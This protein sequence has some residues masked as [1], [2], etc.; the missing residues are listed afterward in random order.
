ME[1]ILA[2]AATR[3]DQLNQKSI[4]AV[5]DREGFLLGLWDM[6]HRLP[7]QLP[8]IVFPQ[9]GDPTLAKPVADILKIYSL[10]AGAVTRASTAAFLSSDGEAFTSRTAGF[11]I[12]Q[13][14]PPGIRNTSTGPLVGVGLSSL[15]FSD[16][17]RVNIIPPNNTDYREGLRLFAEREDKEWSLV[18]CISFLTM[19][20]MGITSALSKDHHFKQAGFT[21]LIGD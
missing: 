17:N 8:V 13:H 1:L 12:Q 10:A 2:Q 7:R 20:R 3:A 14:F 9:L 15:F 19:R 16:V 5:T 11:I 6:A 4:I 18:D 21:L